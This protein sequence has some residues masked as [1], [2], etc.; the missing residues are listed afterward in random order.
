M[1]KRVEDFKHVRKGV[2]SLG[3]SYQKLYNN[4]VAGRGINYKTIIPHRRWTPGEEELVVNAGRGELHSIAFRLNRTY[5][6]VVLKRG[7]LLS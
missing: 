3:G 4:V 6:S 1:K 2:T 5:R 7:R